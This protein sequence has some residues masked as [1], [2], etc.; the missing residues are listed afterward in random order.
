MLRGLL[1]IAAPSG[2][3]IKADTTQNLAAMLKNAGTSERTPLLIDYLSDQ[4]MRVLR[5][6]NRPR[7]DAGFFDIGMDSLMAIE[8]RNRISRDLG[9]ARP[10]PSTALFDYPNVLALAQHLNPSDAKPKPAENEQDVLSHLL[11][12]VADADIDRFSQSEFDALIED[13]LRAI[14]E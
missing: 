11:E 13:A 2:E 7:P 3:A 12:G 10:I 6:Q 5:L 8:L 14:G 9:L 1:P 4:V